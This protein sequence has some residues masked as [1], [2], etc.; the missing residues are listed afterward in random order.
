MKVLALTPIV[1]GILA[2]TVITGCSKK[3]PEP[4][5]KPQ[6][7]EYKITGGNEVNL[8]IGT[9]YS[10]PVVKVM[11]EKK[12]ITYTTKGSVDSKKLGTYIVTYEGKSCS[13]KQNYTVKVVPSSCS[14]KLSGANPLEL[15]FGKKY[16]E[17]GF[18]VKDFNNKVLK[19]SSTGAI[20]SSKEGSYT[21]T[22]KG[23]GCS[24]TA[25]RMVKVL[26]KVVPAACTYT[27][28]GLTADKIALGNTYKD[29]GVSV[30]SS[31]NE[32][33]SDVV[34]T[35]IVNSTKAGTYTIE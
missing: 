4:E 24:N 11:Q 8:A 31:K 21:L 10:K 13:N 7:C 19:E 26:A 1:L 32:I 18:E 27:L 9:A 25:K 28:S 22:Y 12:E 3:D 29:P 2:S 30:R 5:K 34:K 15:A 17:P 6:P 33:V 35:G 16:V 20:N 14:Y 23:E